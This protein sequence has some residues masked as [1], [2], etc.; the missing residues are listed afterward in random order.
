MY[1][2][3]TFPKRHLGY[4]YHL[5]GLMVFVSSRRRRKSRSGEEEEKN[6]IKRI[7]KIVCL[8]SRI[9]KHRRHILYSL[10]TDL[11]K[12]QEHF[13]VRIFC[14]STSGMRDLNG[15]PSVSALRLYF[16]LF[17]CFLFFK[18]ILTK[19]KIVLKIYYILGQMLFPYSK[20]TPSQTH[21]HIHNIFHFP[22]ELME[23]WN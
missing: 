4:A 3:V 23:I 22:K 9:C 8:K 19:E 20:Y 5:Y 2:D 10:T 11:I 7:S 14:Q 17:R 13:Q 12:I 6:K 1:L 16:I 21:T 15:I 18:V